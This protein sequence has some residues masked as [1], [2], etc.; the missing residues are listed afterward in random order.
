MQA[1]LDELK[2]GLD[3]QLLLTNAVRVGVFYT[4]AQISS[5]HVG[6]AFTPRDLAD[7]VCCPKSAAQG[8]PVGKMIGRRALELAEFGLSQSPLRRAVG[9]AV[10]NALSALAI[11]R[12]GVGGAETRVGVDALAAAE[13]G[14]GDSVAMVGAFAPFIRKLRGKVARL[15]VIDKHRDTLKPEELEF[16]RPPEEAVPVLSDASVV[17]ITGSALV[18]G[19]LDELLAAASGA[20]RV[21]MAGPTASPWPPPFFERGVDILGGIRVRDGFALLNLV[22]EGGSGYSFESVA[23]KVCIIRPG[24]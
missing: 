13:V 1:W 15:R 22:S 24:L 19:G 4:A 21:V 3:S 11:E 16:W 20:R 14:E 17:L 6:V 23:E 12:W 18:E 9:T 5:G 2:R 7:T 10:L 8:L